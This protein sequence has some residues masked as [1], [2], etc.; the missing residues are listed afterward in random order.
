MERT[1]AF[2][3][4]CGGYGFNFSKSS[5]SSLFIVAAIIVKEADLVRLDKELYLIREQ[6]FGGSEIKSNGIKGK[7]TRRVRILNKVLKLPFNI[8]TLIVDKR[9]VLAEHGISRNKKY[10]YEFINNLIYKELRGAYPSLHIVTDEVG[11]HEF[12]SEFSKYVKSHRKRISLFDMEEFDIVDSKSTNGVQLADLIA[13]TLSYVYE[14]NKKKT[15]PIDIDYLRMLEKKLLLIKFFPKSYDEKLFEHSEG[16]SNYNKDI[17]LL[18][19]RKAEQY[20]T[21]HAVSSDEDVQRQVFTLKYLLFRFKYNN[22]R[23]YISTKEL[24][25]ALQRANYPRISEQAFRSRVIGVLR[26]RGVIISSSPRGYKLPS[27]EK[28]IFDYYQHVSGVVLPM[29]HRLNL[30][31]ETLRLGTNGNFN[32]LC[33]ENFKGLSVIIDAMKKEIHNNNPSLQNNKQPAI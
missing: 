21:G 13:G 31:N 3:D 6:E 26:D 9:E 8:L 24:M 17:A 33:G 29:L 18:S 30:C 5:T 7:H 11:E 4:E 28:E 25:N 15:I 1:Y 22:L 2:I 20:V 23:R 14:D 16:D 32:I 19:Y 27:T 12:A 10:F